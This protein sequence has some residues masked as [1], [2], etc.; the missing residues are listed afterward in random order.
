MK[1]IILLLFSTVIFF[2][3]L[4]SQVLET[5]NWCLSRCDLVGDER[6]NTEL[7]YLQLKNDS[8][9]Q[10]GQFDSIKRIPLRVGIIQEDTVDVE[11]KEIVIRRAIDNLNKSFDGSNFLF[12]IERVDVIIS[13]LKLEDLSENFYDPYNAFSDKYDE[14][15]ILSIYI[16]N[17][18]DEFCDI[19]STTI[20][21]GR[22]GGFSYVLSERTNNI[23]MSR[24]DISNIK[25][26]AHEMG[27]FW[28]LYHTFEE[29]QFGKDNFSEANCHLLGDRICDTPPDPG[30][31]FEVYVNYVSCEVLSLKTEEGLE[32]KPHIENYM[33]YYKP[34]Y[35]KEFSFTPGQLRVMRV[36]ANLP[37]RSIFVK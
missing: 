37:F 3:N 34:C 10:L 28:G 30:P 22:T 9:S 16:F 7:L 5:K 31:I 19:T 36:A 15:N 21:C 2:N 8:I 26:L 35:L 18:R 20:S 4:N 1:K 29:A 24:F 13:K 14:P 23:V 17:H 27:H 33:S 12:Y 25:V 11:I 6:N 32:Y